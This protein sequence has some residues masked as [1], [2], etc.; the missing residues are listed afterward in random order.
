MRKLVRIS[1]WVLVVGVS[2]FAI[3]FLFAD[4]GV[5]PHQRPSMAGVYN[6][7]VAVFGE[8]LAR[9]LWVSAVLAFVAGCVLGD[10]K[11]LKQ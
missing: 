10:R 8:P 4:P 11:V 7:M 9:A 5:N 2:S 1:F 6:G 3:L